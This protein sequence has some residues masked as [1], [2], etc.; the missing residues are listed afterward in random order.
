MENR[1]KVSNSL[2]S[3]ALSRHG[4]NAMMHN[5][6]ESNNMMVIVDSPP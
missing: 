5:E 2:E 1:K 4:K 3:M 6:D